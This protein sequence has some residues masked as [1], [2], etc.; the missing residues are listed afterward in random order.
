M[1]KSFWIALFA[2]IVAA[3][4]FGTAMAADEVLA[5]SGDE[6]LVASCGTGQLSTNYAVR[7]EHP[8]DF[9]ALM[10]SSLSGSGDA[11]ETVVY[12]LSIF[13]FTGA[14]GDFA[15]AYTGNTWTVNGPATVTVAHGATVAFNV[16][17]VIPGGATPGNSDSV[18]VTAS[19]GGVDEV[20]TINTGCSCDII[21]DDGTY[22]SQ[23]G[24]GKDGDG[25][26][27]MG[28]VFT[29]SGAVD[30]T[31]VKMM[32][33][34]GGSTPSP[35]P[36]RACV[37]NAT[38]AGGPTGAPIVCSAEATAPAFDVWY[39]VNLPSSVPVN[40][41]FA[42][43]L[44]QVSS[45]LSIGMDS[46]DVGR[47]W[48][49]TDDGSSWATVS[50]IGFPG[51][52]LLRASFCPVDESD[53]SG[54]PDDFGYT[55]DDTEPY[56]W[57]DIS[58]S[59]TL[60]TAGDEFVSA[61]LALGFEFFF[62]GTAYTTTMA[63]TNG[64]VT[65]NGTTGYEIDCGALGIDHFAGKWADMV[66]ASIGSV[67]YKQVT[68][69]KGQQFVVQY[70]GVPAWESD[71][72]LTTFQVVLE[73]GTNDIVVYVQDPLG[74]VA[75]D[76]DDDDDDATP[77]GD[78]DDD[79]TTP[80]EDDDDDDDND[81]NDDVTDDDMADDDVSDD[82]GADDDDTVDEGDDDDDDDSCGC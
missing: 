62:Y 16:E 4:G 57:N 68:T 45:F 58:G 70:D 60:L 13:N 80:A 18:T 25:P 48:A 36:F 82:D 6:A 37:Y 56:V 41:D 46:T 49:S 17:H 75:D 2:V 77:P 51:T 64:H 78:H 66:S 15:V 42:V 32:F 74:N 33:S 40:G 21:Y 52:F 59:G 30:I 22:E 44:D 50:S 27:Y 76:D 72:D 69:N 65:F 8:T 14:A 79:D 1:R 47:S 55:W 39:Q 61:P 19:L 63:T 53:A 81:D 26:C 71:V 23:L 38:L 67:Y 24:C 31:N 35:Y 20:A 73:E 3:F 12:S 29:S 10:P 11:G 7:F 43:A 54:G 34:S 9:F 28:N 5:I